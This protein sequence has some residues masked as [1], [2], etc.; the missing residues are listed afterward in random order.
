MTNG[1]DNSSFT[2]PSELL[3][4]AFVSTGVG[5][6]YWN[7]R[8]G[9][10]WFDP[11]WLDML[12]LKEFQVAATLEEWGKRIHSDDRPLVMNSLD[13]FKSM[14]IPVYFSEHRILT[15]DGQYLWVRDSGKVI[16]SDEEGRPLIAMGTHININQLK[17]AERQQ[18][19]LQLL[20]QSLVEN[21]TEHIVRYHPETEVITFTNKTFSTQF[22]FKAGDSIVNFVQTKVHPDDKNRLL[23]KWNAVSNDQSPSH[24]EIQIDT[25]HG[26]QWFLLE[27]YRIENVGDL[28]PEVQVVGRNINDR[29]RTIEELMQARQI[30]E[31][32]SKAKTQFISKVS[33][34]LR[35]PLNSILGYSTLLQKTEMDPKSYGFVKAI[36]SN[37]RHLKLL[38][39][40]LLDFSK[41]ESNRMQVKISA[42]NLHT[43]LD[44]VVADI[45]SNLRR[46]WR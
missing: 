41:I 22:G 46:E 23:K 18:R 42:F 13:D 37:S 34:E 12:N 40:D 10:T 15:G 29:I 31:E 28:A 43:M 35:T 2:P 1:T 4:N 44:E 33:H 8:T 14:R 19:A 20:Y 9:T 26:Y 17:Q 11:S 24:I 21:Q 6:W 5:I 16:E 3:I 32:A 30:A 27:G 36:Y 45:L 39:D 7:V 38:I 25:H